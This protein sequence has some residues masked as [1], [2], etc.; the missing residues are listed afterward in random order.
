MVGFHHLIP[1]QGFQVNVEAP[2]A[3]Q[4]LEHF[5]GGITQRFAVV[6]LVTQGQGTVATP[7]NAVDLYVGF[8]IAQVVLRCQGF[9]NG[10]IAVL[11]VYRR[12]QQI[13]LLIVIEDA[14]QLEIADHFG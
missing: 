9:T 12:N 3:V 14:E 10:S 2:E 8:A 11:V 7:V 5:V 13:V 6:L 4:V 1:L